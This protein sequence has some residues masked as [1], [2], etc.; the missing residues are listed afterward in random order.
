MY[1]VFCI[2]GAISYICTF[3]PS[4]LLSSNFNKTASSEM[5]SGIRKIINDPVYGFI[6]LDHPAYF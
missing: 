5:A 4:C 1:S 6:T 3:V 2:P